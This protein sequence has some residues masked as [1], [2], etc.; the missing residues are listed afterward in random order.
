MAST[1]S[2][3]LRLELIGDGDQSGIWGQTTNNNLGGLIEQAIGGVV[4]ITLIDANYTL[5]NFNGVV[6]EARNAVIIATGALS[7]QRNIIAPLV[8]KTYTI[9]NSTTGGFGVQ[10]IGPSGTGVIIPNGVTTSVFCDGTNFLPAFTGSTGNQSINGNLLV[11][12]T[13]TLVGALGG[14]TATFSGAISSVNPSFTGTPTA[15]TA[16]SG[17]NTTQIATTAFVQN[18]AGA[19]GTMSTQNANAVAITGGTINGTTIGASTAA[20]IAGTTGSFSGNLASL[21][22]VSGTSGV[23]GPVSGTTGTFSSTVSGSSFTGAGTGLT[24]TASSLTAGAATTATNLSGGSVSATTGTFSGSVTVSTGGATGG[25]II[26]ADDG[27]IV[28]LNN[29][30]CSMRFTSG[31][32]IYSGNRTGS[33]VITLGS[34][35]VVTASSFSGA[36]TGLTGTASSLTVGNATNATTVTTT[37]ASG[38]T[39]TTQAVGTN[40]T[41]IATTAFVRSIIPAGVILMWSGS[42][43]SIPSGWVLCNG[44]SGTPDL[45]DRF[46]VGAGSGYGVGATGGSPDAIVVSHTHTATSTD[47][48][49]VHAPPTGLNSPYLSNPFSGD[50]SIDSSGFTGPTERNPVAGNSASAV[51]N[52][53]TTVASA[54]SSGTNANLPPYYALAYIMKT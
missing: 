30:Y 33:A 6:D 32:Q 24:G 16:I 34:N 5:T 46:I 25:G 14:S 20:S 22:S 50:G 19:L 51:A 2:P 28:D 38:A 11:T 36:G 10:I 4:T 18:V 41:T 8:E 17:T 40:N 54:G 39:G 53:T 13:T 29:S 31:V 35:G 3:S 21:G 52:I 44:G 45:R 47:S 15:P 27:D 1:F 49:H 9:R 43:A 37:V 23:F 26:L 7:A 42:I 48:G 12:G